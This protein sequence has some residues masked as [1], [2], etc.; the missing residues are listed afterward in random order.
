M[1]LGRKKI[2]IIIFICVA[3]CAVLAYYQL[4]PKIGAFLREWDAAY[5]PSFP[6]DIDPPKKDFMQRL[7]EAAI[8]RTKQDVA[9]VPAYVK[10]DYPG[11]D[12]PADT[13]VCTDVVIRSY[14]KLGI[15]LQKEVHE[16]MRDN[17]HLYPKIWRLS[18]PDTN[19]DHRRVPNLMV[20]FKRKGITL[21]ITDNPDDYF[22]GDIVAWKLGSGR[23]HIGIVVGKNTIVHNI[24]SGPK[25]E[26]E[27]FSWKIIGHFR[28]FGTHKP[29]T[30]TNE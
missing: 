14:R 25:M 5:A 7:A 18:K 16:D 22:T 12:V 2:V 8:D 9:Y 23:T 29:G 13:G 17:F 11:G 30:K 27:L 26:P 10:I 6:K 20:F 1:K 21:P 24:G 3:L 4:T 15:D 19:I 28:Y